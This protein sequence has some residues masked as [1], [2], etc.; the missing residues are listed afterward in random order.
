MIVRIA[1]PTVVGLASFWAWEKSHRK[2]HKVPP[3][4]NRA[5]CLPYKE[6]FELY[7]NAFS[8]CSMKTRVCLAELQIPYKAHPIDLIETRK[9]ETISRHF[10]AVNP[11]GTVP[12]LVHK[13]HPI[14][15]SH[16]QIRYA[17]VHA[18]SY[19]PATHPCR[20]RAQG[21]DRA[22]YRLV[23]HY[24]GSL[25]LHHDDVLTPGCA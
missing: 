9:Y 21:K 17:A 22:L 13:G 4:I 2:T 7:H 5:V 20:S 12:V 8:L 14:Y 1:V 24:R 18:P 16:E 19:F 6:E 10:L 23:I 15:E 3:G 25:L 11:A